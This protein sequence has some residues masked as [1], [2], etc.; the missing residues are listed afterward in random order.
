MAI[1]AISRGTLSGGEALA[2][3]VARQL[4]Y[5]IVSREEIVNSTDWFGIPMDLPGS[6]VE[7]LPSYWDRLAG[8]REAYLDSFQAALCERARRGNLVYH[9][10]AGHL[11]IPDV[12]VL[13]VRVVANM[14]YRVGAMIRDRQMTREEALT[15]IARVDAERKEWVRYLYGVEWEDP[16]LYDAVLNLSHVGLESACSIIV[17]MARLEE[18][19]LTPHARE[20]LEDTALRGRISAALARDEMTAEIPLVVQTH[21]GS[22][23]ISGTASREV[24]DSLPSVLSEVEG[25]REVSYQV[26]VASR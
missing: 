9:G 16:I 14:E 21:H 10:H 19:A 11:L 24:V 17:H 20:I 6:Q 3:L 5:P 22:A 1:I 2:R 15:Y 13:R 7:K 18:F 8:E 4:G 23:T 12:P 26:E 25:L